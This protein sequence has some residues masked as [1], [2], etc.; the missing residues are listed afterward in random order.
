LQ[1]STV[2][3][4]DQTEHDLMGSVLTLESPPTV[5]AEDYETSTEPNDVV[6]IADMYVR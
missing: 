4:G 5:F 2:C 3:L 6:K 1:E